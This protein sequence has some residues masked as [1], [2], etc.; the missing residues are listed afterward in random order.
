[1]PQIYDMADPD[2][3]AAGLAAAV[4]AL[5]AGG[6]VAV[7]TETVYGLAADAGSDAAVAALYRAKSRP[8]RNPLIVHLPSASAA[9]ALAQMN[10]PARR[11][12]AA[13]WPGPLTVVVPQRPDSGLSRLATAG[14]DSVALRVPDLSLIHI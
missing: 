13:F 5:R 7:P 3:R 4:R 9:G 6:L 2:A 8:A 1:M 14:L 10:D 11:A 12:A